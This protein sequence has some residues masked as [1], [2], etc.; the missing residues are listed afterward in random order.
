MNQVENKEHRSI[1]DELEDLT[2]SEAL[3]GISVVIFYLIAT[4]L[5]T[6]LFNNYL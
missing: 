2:W 6:K 5:I 4:D 1:D 3:S